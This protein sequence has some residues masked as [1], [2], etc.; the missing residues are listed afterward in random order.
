[1]AH[2]GLFS[3]PDQPHR[4]MVRAGEVQVNKIS[5][6]LVS[7]PDDVTAEL[8]VTP[9]DLAYIDCKGLGTW[10]DSI[11][12][13]RD[14][15]AYHSMR[16]ID[17]EDRPANAPNVSY[18]KAL[19]ARIKMDVAKAQAMRQPYTTGLF[20]PTLELARGRSVISHDVQIE[21]NLYDR[22]ALIS[23]QSDGFIEDFTHGLSHEYWA[24]TQDPFTTGSVCSIA[25]RDGLKEWAPREQSLRSA[26]P[27]ALEIQP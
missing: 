26:R 8:L 20:M 4:G 22:A 23:A 9:E 24:A 11:H 19:A 5:R 13:I 3:H 17:I 25:F 10:L 2:E 18:E 14:I 15:R 21:H 6:Y 12:R 16:G 1:M 27:V 7:L